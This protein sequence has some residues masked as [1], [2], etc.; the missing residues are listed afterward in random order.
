M[1]GKRIETRGR[2]P[3]PKHRKRSERM[4]C[5]VTP[6]E[7]RKLER[8]ARRLGVSLSELIRSAALAVAAKR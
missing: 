4:V 6:R 1:A 5:K 7:R 8:A 2:P 3:L